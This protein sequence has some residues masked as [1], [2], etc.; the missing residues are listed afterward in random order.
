M[1]KIFNL[2]QNIQP[3]ICRRKCGGYLA[4]SEEGSSLRIGVIGQSEEE[5]RRL[6]KQEILEWVKIL[7]K[8]DEN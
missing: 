2:I 3:K 7:G 6:F 5:A 8:A 4:V 1:K